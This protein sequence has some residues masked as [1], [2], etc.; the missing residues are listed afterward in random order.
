MTTFAFN[1]AVFIFGNLFIAAMWVNDKLHAVKRPP[2]SE[3]DR[4]ADRGIYS[5]DTAV[6][7]LA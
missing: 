4:F 2:L 5:E 1:S 3:H 6:D 7:P